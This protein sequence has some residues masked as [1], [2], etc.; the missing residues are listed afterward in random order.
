[1]I[2]IISNEY[3]YHATVVSIELRKRGA[4]TYLFDTASFPSI[5]NYSHPLSTAVDGGPRLTGPNPLD[6]RRVETVWNRR[7]TPFKKKSFFSP[8]DG[9]FVQNETEC[10]LRGLWEALGDCFW[11][12]PYKSS[13]RAGN[14]PCQLQI[15]REVGL[16]IPSTLLTND[17]DA[18]LRFWEENEGKVVYKPFFF[19]AREIGEKFFGVYTNIV[20][21]KHLEDFR[22]GI[23]H[24]PC[25]FQRYI[26]KRVEFRVTI[27]GDLTFT[28]EIDSQGSER[29]R[30]DWRRYNLK[31]TR[32]SPSSIPRCIEVKL[33]EL[34]RRLDLIFGCVDLIETPE[35]EFVFLEINEGGQWYW[36]EELTGLPITAGVVTL[37]LQGKHVLDD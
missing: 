36:V 8:E 31:N 14:K 20:S 7:P 22:L 15:A 29:S 9:K 17:P 16:T 10:G 23:R 25:L 34:M 35:G 2:L 33:R 30:I 13:W 26:E 5:Y 11:V 19:S 12:N 37:L 4:S 27:V 21:R 28:S 18:A 6:L 24:A 32:Y 3:D 1:M